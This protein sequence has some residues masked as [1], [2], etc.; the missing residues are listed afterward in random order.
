M[1]KKREDR[2]QSAQEMLDALERLPLVKKELKNMMHFTDP[3]SHLFHPE[4]TKEQTSNTSQLSR[5]SESEHHQSSAVSEVKNSSFNFVWVTLLAVMVVFMWAGWF[6]WVPSE[7]VQNVPLESKVI[8]P[9]AMTEKGAEE[10]LQA[11]QAAMASQDFKTAFDQFEKLIKAN[12]KS[13]AVL[14]G[15]AL[16]AFHLKNYDAAADAFHQLSAAFPEE[17]G[18]YQPFIELAESKAK[19]VTKP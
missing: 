4:F 17:A 19:K 11:G 10:L 2:Y 16:S 5:P 12:V 6:L 8:A 3:T 18:R 1:A 9:E 14:T 15:M 13:R 7:E